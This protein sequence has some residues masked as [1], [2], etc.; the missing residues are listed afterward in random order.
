M[1]FKQPPTHIF[2]AHRLFPSPTN[3]VLCHCGAICGC[4]NILKT[5]FRRFR[6]SHFYEVPHLPPV[7]FL[8]WLNI[9]QPWRTGCKG[10]VLYGFKA[11]GPCSCC[12]P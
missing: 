12:S 4:N 5:W 10:V 2:L 9:P 3:I 6:S 7:F 1:K 11:K 8:D